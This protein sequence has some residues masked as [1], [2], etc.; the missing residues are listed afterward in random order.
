ML[1]LKH[2]LPDAHT[3]PAATLAWVGDA[4]YEMY[5]RSGLLSISHNAHK[6]SRQAVG[7]VN[8]Q[9]QSRLLGDITDQLTERE[10]GVVARGRNHRGSVP[11]NGDMQAY[12]RATGLEAL[13]GYLYLSDQEERL[14]WVF[15]QLTQLE[16]EHHE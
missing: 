8:H 1:G 3:L 13:V 9:C 10:A 11:K 2:P 6:L 16:G 4:V 5:V 15:A 12:R 14:N 7:M